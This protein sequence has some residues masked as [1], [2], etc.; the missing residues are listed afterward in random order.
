MFGNLIN[1]DTGL[2]EDFQRLQ[3]E[4][5]ALFRPATGLASIRAVARG[6]FPTVNIGST[7]DAVHVYAFAPGLNRDT[8][9]LSIQRN[10][11]TITG[12]RKLE[13]PGQDKGIYH[14]RE[15]FTGSFTRTISL[16]EDVDPEK[17]SAVYRDGVL[18]ISV[19]KQESF[20]PRQIQIQST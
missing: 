13:A 2:W 8:L 10:L 1:F 15:R 5:D 9:D 11:L 12:E 4:M 3:R 18:V 20:K 6:S 16:P 19:G 14:L 17:V 7:P